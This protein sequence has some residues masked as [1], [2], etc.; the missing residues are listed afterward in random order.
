M[1]KQR[2]GQ[3]MVELALVL[4][5]VLLLLL[6]MLDFGRAYVFGVAIQQGAREAARYGAGAA[7]YP[8]TITDTAIRQRLIDASYPALQ[9]CSA[10]A[11]TCTDGSGVTWAITISPVSKTSGAQLGVTAQGSMPLLTGF[12]TGMVGISQISLQ[13]AAMM[14]II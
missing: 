9:G 11:S 7:Y 13:G 6:G 8:S 2:A 10:T 4:P 12:L 1:A 3:A 5:V 14:V